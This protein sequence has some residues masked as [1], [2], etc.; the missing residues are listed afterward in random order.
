ML[1][2]LQRSF[3]AV[4]RTQQARADLW[5]LNNMSDRDLHDIGI[6]RGEIR[7]HIYGEK[8]NRKTKQVS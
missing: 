1:N 3:R 8:S 2:F 6:S 5:L 4:Q 7:E